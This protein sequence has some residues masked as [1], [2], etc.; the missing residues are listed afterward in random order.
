VKAAINLAKELEARMILFHA[1]HLNL[2]PFG[3]ANVDRLMADLRSEA[4][5]KVKILA[6]FAQ[7]AAVPVQCLIGQGPVAAAILNVAKQNSASLMVMMAG[8][9]GW[10]RE[11]FGNNLTKCV[12]RNAACTVLVLS[13]EKNRADESNKLRGAPSN[14]VEVRDGYDVE[15]YH[16]CGRD[17][18]A[19]AGT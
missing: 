3:P 9:A 1:I 6:S 4:A 8:K 19:G 16:I 14:L 13:P 15:Q 2:S 11:F 10:W 7:M 18:G 12:A 17:A 5:V